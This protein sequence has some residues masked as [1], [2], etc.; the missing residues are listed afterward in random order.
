[1]AQVFHP[2]FRHAAPA[3]AGLGVPTAFNF[4][5][6]LT[7]PDQPRAAAVGVA[8]RRMAPIVA[9]VL[10]AR[11]VSALVFRGDDGLD[12]LTT[13]GSSSVW[14]VRDG[15]VVEQSF[16]PADLGVPRASIEHLRG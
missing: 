1:F 4:L 8:D 3:R 10:A 13:S 12:E 2:S 7:N 5:G 6:P 11:G 16:D 14:E 9:G 15:D